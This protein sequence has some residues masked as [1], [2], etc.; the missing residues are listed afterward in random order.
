MTGE[1]AEIQKYKRTA[2]TI[3]VRYFWEDTFFALQIAKVAWFISAALD[4]VDLPGLNPTPTQ[5]RL[6][7]TPTILLAQQNICLAF[8]PLCGLPVVTEKQQQLS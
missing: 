8:C 2:E 1:V 5:A 4:T 7:S 3:L 6:V